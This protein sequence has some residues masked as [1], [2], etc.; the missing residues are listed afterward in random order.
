MEPE[1]ADQQLAREIGRTAEEPLAR[2]MFASPLDL[3]ASPEAQHL[4]DLPGDVLVG[5]TLLL[6][7]DTWSPG[8]LSTA[9]T[10]A[11]AQATGRW[12]AHV[13]SM[14]LDRLRRRRLPWSSDAAALALRLVSGSSGMVDIRRTSVALSV[15]TRVA[16]DGGVGTA[17]H[18]AARDLE[19]RLGDA[20]AHQYGVKDLRVRARRLVA[21]CAPTDVVDLGLVSFAD[22]W[23]R[24]AVEVFDRHAAGW[25]DAPELARLLTTGG[26]QKPTQAWRRATRALVEVEAPAQRIVAGWLRALLDLPEPAADPTPGVPTTLLAPENQQLARAAVRAAEWLVDDVDD[27]L[28]DLV[29]L[30]ARPVA[31]YEPLALPLATVAIDV[32]AARA[33]DDGDDRLVALLGELDR[34]D[35]LRRVGARHP[36]LRAAAEDRATTLAAAKR[37][38]A[39]R[40]QRGVTRVDLHAA[41]QEAVTT[42]LAEGLRRMGFSGDGPAFHLDEPTHWAMLTVHRP[43]D[44]SE[45]EVQLTATALVVDR[46]TWSQMQDAG[47]VGARPAG[48]VTY[49]PPVWQRDVADLVPRGGTVGSPLGTST[50][51][52]RVVFRFLHDVEVHVLPAMR[53]AMA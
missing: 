5:A 4:L 1:Q 35:L 31:A 26:G 25:D 24:H 20:P 34:V 28:V 15:A 10:I 37:K 16:K 45:P 6:L 17:M 3:D 38:Q 8:P 23:G 39:R 32:L 22:D 7:S 21:S 40:R 41:L 52:E 19:R 18:D 30:G 42:T 27:L 46:R 12:D 29:H 47:L 36:P 44:R 48:R 13:A 2:V 14:L 43:A 33:E 49:G 51:V 50:D 11:T 9:A 53:D